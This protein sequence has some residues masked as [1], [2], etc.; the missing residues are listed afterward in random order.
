M[1]LDAFLVELLDFFDTVEDLVGDCF[2][3]DDV[4]FR[5]AFFPEAVVVCIPANLFLEDV[6]TTESGEPPSVSSPDIS[7]SSFP[8]LAF[9]CS[10]TDFVLFMYDSSTDILRFFFGLCILPIA[11]FP[12]S[13]MHNNLEDK[14]STARDADVRGVVN[15]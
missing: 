15:S 14:I 4:I 10:V 12:S 1:L 8:L 7:L 6:W 13:S 2:L 11:D 9:I 3:L 5:D